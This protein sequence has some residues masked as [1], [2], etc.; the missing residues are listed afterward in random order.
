MRKFLPPP[1]HSLLS[2]NSQ[3]LQQSKILFCTEIYLCQKLQG[4]KGEEALQR[5]GIDSLCASPGITQ[6]YTSSVWAEFDL[7]GDFVRYVC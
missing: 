1:P 4:Q 2:F 7:I 6:V 3:V 5:A